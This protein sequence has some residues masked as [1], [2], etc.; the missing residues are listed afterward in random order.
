MPSQFWACSVRRHDVVG[1]FMRNW[2]EAEERGDA[3][4]SVEADRADAA[5][6]AAHLAIP[7]HEADFVRQYWT[8][9]F[10]D[11][12]DQARSLLKCFP[13]V[14]AEFQGLPEGHDDS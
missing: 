3:R 9:V 11:F 4:C 14:H 6:V 7:L 13:H 10:S 8:H 2:D 12:V 5:A 1:V